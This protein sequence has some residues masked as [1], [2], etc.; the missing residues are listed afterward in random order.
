MSVFSYRQ[1][2]RLTR[3]P[4]TD[5]EDASPSDEQSVIALVGLTFEA[6]IAAGPGVCVV[7][8]H[9][10]RE[11]SRQLARAIA[12]GCRSIVSFG[13]AGGLAPDLRPGD[14]VIGSEI[15][16]AV[17]S[18][19]TDPVWSRRLV[20]AV[21]GSWH[22][23]LLGVDQAICDPRAKR[24]MYEAT[25]AIAV[26][27]ESHIV[28]RVAET[29]GLSFAAI[30]VVVDPAHRAVPEAALAAMRPGGSPDVSAIVR[31]V[32][33]RPSQVSALLR[34]AIDAYAART[35][36]LRLRRQLGPT[37]GLLDLAAI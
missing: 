35:T 19:A 32:I 3:R 33:M 11:L 27:M 21:P 37:F 20:D 15:V 7:C 2:R 25:G 22:A 28:A 18:R 26:D 29:H 4:A 9:V 24:A 12:S 16:D 23:P 14:W 34:I 17:T 13:V 1:T 5:G 10:E 36:L 8:R 6:R 30:R 31:S